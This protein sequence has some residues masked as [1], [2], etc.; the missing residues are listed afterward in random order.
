MGWNKTHIIVLCKLNNFRYEFYPLNSTKQFS[1]IQTLSRSG[2]NWS[3]ISFGNPAPKHQHTSAEGLLINPHL[4][5]FWQSG[6]SLVLWISAV[7]NDHLYFFK[8]NFIIPPI[9]SETEY[10]LERTNNLRVGVKSYGEKK[11]WKSIESAAINGR[12]DCTL[13]DR[14]TPS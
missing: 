9:F 11:S 14:L 13:C 3:K 10:L 5:S 12:G 8:F 2:G 1:Q 7:M 4:L 6:Q